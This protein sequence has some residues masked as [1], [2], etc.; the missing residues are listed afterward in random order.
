MSMLRSDLK[1]DGRFV[2]GLLLWSQAVFVASTFRNWYV[3]IS[4]TALAT[5]VVVL[6]DWAGGGESASSRRMLPRWAR[7]LLLFGGFLI[8]TGLVALGR[9]GR[10][11]GEEINIVFVGVDILAHAAL[12]ANLIVWVLHPRRGHVAMLAL[13]LIVVL[14][15][16]AAGGASVSLAAQTTVALAT[17]LAFT[18]GA[19]IILGSERHTGGLILARDRYADRS[20]WLSTVFSTFLVTSAAI[21]TPP[22]AS[23]FS[24]LPRSL[25]GRSQWRAAYAP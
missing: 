15:A 22:I 23:I 10:Q 25:C 7:W 19:Q 14:L 13:G 24:L 17:C 2:L 8:I 9:I 4:L 1:L 20:A 6:R 21:R 18:V 12:V 16:V 11:L 5:S 3:V